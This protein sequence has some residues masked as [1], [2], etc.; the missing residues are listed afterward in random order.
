[1]SPQDLDSA[2]GAAARAA[3][4]TAVG[5]VLRQGQSLSTA[6]PAAV[7]DLGTDPER[8]L[9]QELAYGSLRYACRL[10]WYLQ[11]LMQRPLKRRDSDVHGLLLVGLYQLICLQTPAHVAVDTTV[12]ACRDLNKPW[13]SALVNAVLRNLL[14]RWA[15]LQADAATVEQ[16]EFNHP[17]WLLGALRAAWP[18]QWRDIVAAND[19]RP[20]MTLRVNRRR[21]DRTEYLQRLTETGLK[22]SA[23]RH[24]PEGIVLDAPVSVAALPGFAAGDVSVQDEAA[25]LAAHLLDLL[26]DQRVL[27]A[28]AA[29]GGKTAHMLE[30]E[31]R[32]RGLVTVEKDRKRF[33]T[34]KATLDRLN[35]QAQALCAD[36]AQP[37]TWWDGAEFD[38]ILLDAPCT[39]TGVIR[40]HPDIRMLRRVEDLAATQAAQQALLDALWPLLVPGGKLLYA[41]C[42]VL[43]GENQA[44]IRDFIA[45]HADA[46]HLPIGSVWGRPL[47]LGRQILPGEDGM[48]G[49]Y[50]ALLQKA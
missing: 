18:S 14:R 16:A 15:Q 36:A 8:A 27:D 49:F 29:P 11:K 13:A 50:Y 28:C 6:L 20:P 45:R 38:R 22:A 21:S 26:P 34:L 23:T 39:A 3:A 17:G 31:P 33:Q 7:A 48:D 47:D 41:T 19:L 4:A 24:A 37:G 44:R 32:L 9:A 25:Q 35:L 2:P 10:G 1:M 42:S 30:L 46:R 43:P 40:R 5:A 12:A